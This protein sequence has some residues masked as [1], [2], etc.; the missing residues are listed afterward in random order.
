MSLN[1]GIDQAIYV[2]QVLEEL[3][4]KP[5]DTIPLR[6]MVDNQDCHSLA[7]ANVAGR[8]RRLRAEVSRIREALRRGH[9]PELILVKGP[10][11][12]VNVMTKRTADPTELLRIFQTGERYTV[13]DLE[14]E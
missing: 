1:T 3:L 12:L 13:E 11:Q 7:H 9:V 10:K 4:A 8:E 2:K 6:A 14:K 5:E